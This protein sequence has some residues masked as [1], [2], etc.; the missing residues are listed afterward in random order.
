MSFDAVSF[1]YLNPQLNLTSI[2]DAYNYVTNSNAA[3][4]QSNL[5]PIPATFND[6]VFVFD[7]KNAINISGLNTTIRNAMINEG[8]S[9][10]NVEASGE[11]YDTIFRPIYNTS[12]N[13]FQFI[14]PGDPIVFRINSS[15]LQAGDYVRLV[16]NDQDYVNAT[17]TGIIDDNTFTISNSAFTFADGPSS[18]YTLLGIKLYDIS[19]LAKIEYLR[20]RNTNPT[21]FID[22]KDFNYQLY[23][24]LYPDTRLMDPEVAFTNYKNYTGQRIGT[25][26]D[27]INFL[28]SQSNPPISLSNKAVID[29]LTVNDKLTLNFGSNGGG[30]L[31]M[32]GVDIYYIST[33]DRS[34]AL[35]VSPFF[36]G[37][38]T[39]RAIKTYIDRDKLVLST[40]CNLDVTNVVN[41]KNTLNAQTANL[42][43]ANVKVLNV[44]S[45]LNVTA[46]TI[47]AGS[48]LLSG[49]TFFTNTSTFCNAVNF[50]SNLDTLGVVTT[51][52]NLNVQGVANLN[53][54]AIFNSLLTLSSNANAIMYG[55]SFFNG[56]TVMC[57]NFIIDS[58]ATTISYAPFNVNALNVLGISTFSNVIN[59]NA[60]LNANAVVNINSNIYVK[61]DIY[62][63]CNQY[64]QQINA[65]NLYVGS[66]TSSNQL[67]LNITA[68]NIT[69]SNVS[70][71]NATFLNSMTSSASIVN[72]N[73]SNASLSN[74]NV[75]ILNTQSNYTSNAY[76][77]TLAASN[78]FTPTMSYS[79]AIGQTL[80]LTTLHNS[81][82]FTSNATVQNGTFSNLAVVQMSVSNASLSNLSVNTLNVQQVNI[83]LTNVLSNNTSNLYVKSGLADVLNVTSN[84][85]SLER[86][87]NLYASNIY[88]SN[89][90][91]TNLNSLNSYSSNGFVSA[92]SSCNLTF[93]NGTATNLSVM[94]NNVQNA[95]VYN[96]AASNFATLNAFLSNV[97]TSNATISN[98]R[99]VNGNTSNFSAATAT[100]NQATIQTSYLTT[101]FA[102]NINASNLTLHNITVSSVTADLVN[103]TNLVTSNLTG[104]TGKLNYL[105]TASNAS[106]TTT[107]SNLNVKIANA[108]NITASTANFSS[109]SNSNLYSSNLL[110]SNATLIKATVSNITI[111]SGTVS[112]LTLINSCNLSSYTSNA[113]VQ[114]LFTTTQSNGSFYSF[115]SYI[116]NLA[117]S[118]LIVP[119]NVGFSNIK[120]SNL[121]TTNSYASGS[122]YSLYISASNGY[123]K[124]L[125]VDTLEIISGA[126][127]VFSNVSY[128]DVNQLLVHDTLTVSSNTMSPIYGITDGSSSNVLPSGPN[129]SDFTFKNLQVNE[130]LGVTGYTIIGNSSNSVQL[131][132]NGLIQ[133]TNVNSTSDMRLKKDINHMGNYEALESIKKLDPVTFR[134]KNEKDDR[135][136]L[137]FIAQ[138]VAA[139]LPNAIYEIENYDVIVKKKV[140]ALSDIQFAFNNLDIE[141]G[142]NIL[143][144]STD[145]DG[146]CLTHHTVTYVDYQVN[147]MSINPPLA[148]ACNKFSISLEKVKYK[149][150]MGVDYNQLISL[151]VGSVKE[152]SDKIDKI[153]NC[154]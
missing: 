130:T 69:T 43:N 143:L 113:N 82:S 45:N 134:F 41:V 3:G 110:A 26:D 27:F 76:I 16:K 48:N 109:A 114:Y 147:K 74:A 154:H 31:N 9:A 133:A 8:I 127:Q 65:S 93:T 146:I 88:G 87:Q 83:Q 103:T 121:Y 107:T 117:F 11:Y 78:I 98:L 151:L 75:F 22:T 37:L 138:N 33:D 108:S 145:F 111:T 150:V 120:A 115:N 4:L 51:N 141:K 56:S 40:L 61:S 2:E 152:L 54:N 126:N 77:Q 106:V 30:R 100:L 119:S 21:T 79:N 97:Y 34:T 72:A 104:L 60:T 153:T 105:E 29:E 149:N 53:S 17:V 38:I 50:L 64:S 20:L 125:K 95:Q 13:T 57:N 47:L 136:K 131:K 32:S 42:S 24:T 84:I 148:N 12:N 122:N 139:A 137:G 132:V 7:N 23:Q 49:P 14:L 52:S 116:T 71:L 135:V 18:K 86:V 5:D 6:Q 63:Y 85:V 123:I 19:R 58:N 59:A 112:N 28:G 1:L 66:L 101:V 99:V 128:M 90:Y 67:A 10:S 102:S 62:T 35:Q 124:G 142:E 144:R 81:N 129:P 44:T 46:P 70:G 39:E 80:N 89:A 68:S 96:L 73:V 92:L 140:V 91:I 55:Q 36:D 15:N 94:S 118:N 25:V